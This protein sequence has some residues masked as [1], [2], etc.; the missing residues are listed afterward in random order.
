MPR[1]PCELRA[2]EEEEWRRARAHRRL[3]TAERLRRG[4][5]LLG[6]LALVVLGILILRLAGFIG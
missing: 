3:R 1:P 6:G 5:L 2:M 4:A